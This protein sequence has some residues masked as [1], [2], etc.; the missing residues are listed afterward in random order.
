MYRKRLRY[1]RVANGMTQQ[2][3]A[4]I[5]QI[6]RTTYA[7]YETGRSKPDV[8]MLAAFARAFDVS[9]DF[10]I[11]GKEKEKVQLGDNPS[12]YEV[13]EYPEFLSQLTEEERNL[14][15]TFRVIKEKKKI[16]ADIKE[17][18]LEELSTAAE[19]DDEADIFEE[20]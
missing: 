9:L 2:E 12:R 11:N 19:K 17:L 14:V 4:D 6:H 3:V 16:L 7:F 18:Y 10:I 5:L 13:S 20:E 15:M 8:E 1:L